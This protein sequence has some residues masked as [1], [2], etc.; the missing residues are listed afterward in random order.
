M[1]DDAAKY[2]KYTLTERCMRKTEW[3][4]AW[5][6]YLSLFV[7]LAIAFQIFHCNDN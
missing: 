3:V 6:F 4:S 5:H 7:Y 1:D 2:A